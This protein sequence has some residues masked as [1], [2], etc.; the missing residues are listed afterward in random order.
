MWRDIIHAVKGWRRGA[1]CFHLRIEQVCACFVR[2]RFESS[3]ELLVIAAYECW[4]ARTLKNIYLGQWMK[5]CLQCC[6]YG[7]LH[8]RGVSPKKHAVTGNLHSNM[9][10]RSFECRH[11]QPFLPVIVLWG[12]SHD[13]QSDLV[14]FSIPYKYTL[15]TNW[16]NNTGKRWSSST[17]P[18]Y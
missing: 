14:V 11:M 3:C 10:C 15:C 13:Q 5:L 17:I 18:L 7:K 9:S 16:K 6:S 12:R 4:A 2:G 8:R 1:D